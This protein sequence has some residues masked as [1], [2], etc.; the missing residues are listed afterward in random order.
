PRA[1]LMNGGV[2]VADGPTPE[3]LSDRELMA[4]NRLELPYGFDPAFVS[5]RI[6][7]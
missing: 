6:L 3:I 1:V 7:P 4:A 2:M 5:G